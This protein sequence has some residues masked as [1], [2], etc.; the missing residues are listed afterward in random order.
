MNKTVEPGEMAHIYN[1]SIGEVE[2]RG[3]NQIE[4]TKYL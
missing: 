4:V 1:P 3:E 2:A